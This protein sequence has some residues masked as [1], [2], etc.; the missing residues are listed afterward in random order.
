MDKHLVLQILTIC[1][2]TSCVFAA[3][4][5][6]C[7]EHETVFTYTECDSRNGRWRVQ[8]PKN[9]DHCEIKNATAP[10]RGKNCDFSCI[11]GQFLDLK[12]QQCKECPVG[13]YSL[14]S[15]IRFDN[16]EELPDRFT[17][18]SE[19]I[20]FSPYGYHSKVHNC[21]LSKWSP[22]GHYVVSNDDDCTSSLS[23][24]VELRQ[25]GAVSFSYQYP[26][27]D[28]IFHFY[29]QNG[30]CETVHEQN[31]DVFLNTTGTGWKQWRAT[32]KKGPNVLYW[33][34]TGILLGDKTK[35]SPVLI[36][37]IE[38]TG[39]SYTTECVKCQAGFFASSRGSHWCTPCPPNTHSLPGASIC[40]PCDP[41]TQYAP[42]ANQECLE[43][44]P[45]ME[46]DYFATHTACN[47]NKTTMI[48]Y[49]WAEP[50]ICLDTLEDS[51]KLPPSGEEKPCSPCN[52]GF[53]PSEMG[54]EP[55]KSNS[56][57]NGT[58]HCLQCPAST[59]PQYGFFYLW[60]D[61]LPDLMKTSCISLS[62]TDCD[63]DLGWEVVGDQ[64]RT[65]NV[66]SGE[67]YLV[68]I[69]SIA[70]GFM[71]PDDF[72]VYGTIT[73]V[74]ELEC[75]DD[76]QLY[77]MKDV[78][79]KETTVVDSWRGNQDRQTYS[80]NVM[81]NDTALSFTWAFQKKSA[82]DRAG[83]FLVNATNVI[84]SPAD[85]CT[86][87]AAANVQDTRCIPCPVGNYLD[88]DARTC[89]ACTGN[90]RL[91][92]GKNGCEEC[93]EGT[94]A[95]G[96]NTRCNNNCHFLSDKV[97]RH[98]NFSALSRSMSVMTPPSFTS[99]GKKYNHVYNISLC[100]NEGKG[101]AEC[102]DNVTF[103]HSG[104]FSGQSLKKLSGMVC[105][106]TAVNLDTSTGERMSVHSQPIILA[107]RLESVS[108]EPVLNTTD[109]IF[110]KDDAT[111]YNDVVYFMSMDWDGS[112]ECPD[113]RQTFVHLRCD[114]RLTDGNGRLEMPKKCPDGTCNGCDFYYLWRSYEACPICIKEDFIEV[115]GGCE[116]G[117]IV[118]KYI[119]KSYPR[120]C[121]SG[122]DLP[123]EKVEKCQD[124]T[125][126][127]QI[128][129]VGGVSLLFIMCAAVCC[130]WKKSKKLEY[131]YHRLVLDGKGGASGELPAAD[132]CAISDSESDFEDHS[133]EVIFQ[134]K[135]A[136][137]F[138]KKSVTDYESV[139]L[140]PVTTGV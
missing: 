82:S 98:Y 95:V 18:S 21:S 80:Y 113:G 139:L 27:D 59:S 68:L 124:Y 15:G 130:L 106:S 28:V 67:A 99:T 34:T 115:V 79:K 86:P 103:A 24:V 40:E 64:V 117:K 38:I 46:K 22:A 92:A 125:F 118:T 81:K 33:K 104:L 77:F 111:D 97:G 49:R 7:A 42:A 137:L 126:Y 114:P 87:C 140:Q 136:R 75:E 60:W 5:P 78:K 123:D 74:F 23:Y 88:D 66:D 43:K 89:K 6:P 129:I 120:K 84:G 90:T 20:H 16:W 14:G 37:D 107:S 105:R 3:D 131:K 4:V 35:L 101:R 102:I 128:G 108:Q 58:H 12:T 30:Q 1:L 55:C 96:D 54:C 133:D 85:S 11:A 76:C 132:S 26:D 44:P 127:I 51:V 57:S 94:R 62:Q 71:E 91:N 25:A 122:V 36:R 8:V 2:S 110:P 112:D 135:K 48:M 19:S 83:I 61:H 63:Q 56:Y 116:S 29:V 50:K 65:T 47:E 32:L 45:C 100:G 31:T 109:E 70:S 121:R 17:S 13:T 134:K 119:W 41:E 93:G 69:L 53:H 39:V 52:P 9:P 73:F 10:V 72:E 138:G